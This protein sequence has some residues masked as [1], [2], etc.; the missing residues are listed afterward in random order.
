MSNELIYL[1]LQFLFPLI[2]HIS[3]IGFSYANDPHNTPTR[4]TTAYRSEGIPLP[5]I[6][7]NPTPDQSQ[8][9]AISTVRL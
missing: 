7:V 5:K 6:E 1:C 4:R 9:D 3:K 2:D 8:P